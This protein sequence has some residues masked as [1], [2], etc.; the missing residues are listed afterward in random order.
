M[1][2]A[3]CSLD[4]V[5]VRLGG[6]GAQGRLHPCHRLRMVRF[7]RRLLAASDALLKPR[8]VIDR[9]LKIARAEDEQGKKFG[10][11]KILE[12]T[13]KYEMLEISVISVNKF[14]FIKR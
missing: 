10:T 14:N 3:R 12:V 7:V 9:S 5:G 11:Q 8:R 6:G 1:V 2:V 13:K 4:V